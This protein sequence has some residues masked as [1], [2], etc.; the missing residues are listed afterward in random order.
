MGERNRGRRRIT[1]AAERGDGGIAGLARRY[2][3]D[4]DN[5]KRA[6]TESLCV[7]RQQPLAGE[8]FDDEGRPFQAPSV[9][10]GV[11]RS[12]VRDSRCMAPGASRGSDTDPAFTATLIVTAGV[13]RVSLAMTTAPLSRTVR[14]GPRPVPRIDGIMRT[15]RTIRSCDSM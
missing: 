13:V 14:T 6:R 11:P 8:R 7:Q 3:A 1:P 15:A 10:V 2:V 4:D 9:R 12:I 5:G